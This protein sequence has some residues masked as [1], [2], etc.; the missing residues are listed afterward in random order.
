MSKILKHVCTRWLHKAFERLMEQWEALLSFFHQEIKN[1]EI[2]DKKREEAQ[3]TRDSKKRKLDEDIP[4]SQRNYDVVSVEK[5]IFCFLSTP[6]NKAY[7]SFLLY[8]QAHFDQYNTKL[9]SATPQVQYLKTLLQDF[10]KGLFVKF[11]K[12]TQIKSFG[13]LMDIPFDDLE[14]RK[15]GSDLVIG[16]KTYELV[17]EFTS[18][19]KEKNFSSVRNYFSIACVYV[20]K[21]NSQ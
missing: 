2:K 5:K 17:Q 8:S 4:S 7:C 18:K 15:D 3:P 6:A 20:K 13:N 9:Q 10:L 14:C 19:D 11:V 12:P 21:K 16:T 1:D